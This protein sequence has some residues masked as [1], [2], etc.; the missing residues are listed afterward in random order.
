MMSTKR[1]IKW[2]E[3]TA[4][5]PGFHLWD[6]YIETMVDDDAAPVYLRVEGVSV[7]L[8]TQGAGVTVTVEMPRE[9]AL[10]LGLLTLE[11]K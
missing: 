7:A 3:Q 10:E 5:K 11:S 9:M 1:S 6:D 8:T 4:S 2:R